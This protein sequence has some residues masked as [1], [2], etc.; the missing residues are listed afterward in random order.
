MTKY[1]SKTTGSFYDD[2]LRNEYESAG[3]WPANAVKIADELHAELMTAQAAGR[4]IE[5]DAGGLP[6]AVAPPPATTAQLAA[7]ART[8]RS[9]L[10]SA[11]DWTQARDVPDAVADKWAPYRQAL[12]DLPKK[13][14]FPAT[15]TWPVAP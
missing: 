3:S 12:R 15:I 9:K 14:G 13:P 11:S 2:A 7:G 1:F 8:Q 10:L 5:A 4:T 6:V